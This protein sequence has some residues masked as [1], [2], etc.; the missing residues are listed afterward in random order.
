MPADIGFIWPKDPRPGNP[1]KWSKLWRLADVL[2][3]KGPDIFVGRI[4]PRPR[5]C[6]PRIYY[7]PEEP[8]CPHPHPP[9]QHPSEHHPY[10]YNHPDHASH[11]ANISPSHAHAP[12]PAHDQDHNPNYTNTYTYDST[13][14]TNPNNTRT[15]YDSANTSAP[16]DP[17]H[18][19]HP[20]NPPPYPSPRADSPPLYRH[21]TRPYSIPSTN[22]TL[23]P[24][25]DL[26]TCKHSS[27]GHC[28]LCQT[29][30][31]QQA[32]DNYFSWGRRDPAERYDFRMREYRVPD[33]GTWMGR[34]QCGDPSHI[35]PVR[36]WDRV[37]REVPGSGGVMHDIVYG[38]GLGYGYD[39]RICL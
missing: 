7:P 38:G 31:N 2:K 1:R 33:A 29:L 3:G 30:E 19:P 12:A 35:V 37:G 25:D 27:A 10:P 18:P 24:N 20:P 28:P 17:H 14:N 36:F 21:R 6:R 15:T 32:L 39:G 22:W 23:W 8:H 9:P 16:R 4:G 34:V 13:P 5:L 11:P 26:Q